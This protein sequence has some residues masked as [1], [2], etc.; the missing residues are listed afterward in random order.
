MDFRMQHPFTSIVSGMTGSGKSYFVK[1]LLENIEDTMCPKPKRILWLYGQDQSLYGELKTNV[2]SIEFYRGIPPDLDNDEFL[3]TKIPNLII[4]DD[5]MSDCKNDE[6]LTRLFTI[7]SHH[8][9]LSIIF[10]VQNLFLQGREMRNISLNTHY[11]IIFKNPRDNL[12][13]SVLARQM[14]PG[15]SKFLVEAFEDATAC[16]YGYLFLDMKPTTEECYR[17]RTNVLPKQV[18]CFYVPL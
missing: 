12:Q 13:I 16:A 17:V 6:R 2:P 10:L 5:L 11:F 15:K 14:Y 7:G 8:K 9:N 3:D 1:Q 4:I 18:P